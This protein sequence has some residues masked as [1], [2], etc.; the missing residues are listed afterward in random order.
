MRKSLQQ[1]VECTSNLL[2]QAFK[3]S[4]CTR[5]SATNAQ[6]R[7]GIPCF[8]VSL[9]PIGKQ[10]IPV[11]VNCQ[12]VHRIRSACAG[13]SAERVPHTVSVKCC[14]NET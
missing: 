13:L 1:D 7:T 2:I 4:C 11:S 8:P 6:I 9:F 5:Y 3:C 12:S 10:T 14:I